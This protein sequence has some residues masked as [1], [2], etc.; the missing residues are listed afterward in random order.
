MPSTLFCDAGGNHGKVPP[1]SFSEDY[2]G[3]A[4]SHFTA[5]NYNPVATGGSTTG[6]DVIEFLMAGAR[7]VQVLTVS[8]REGTGHVQKMISEMT[9]YMT[10]K[11]WNRVE[12]LIGLTLKYLPEDPFASW[13]R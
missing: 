7:G 3:S 2:I 8:M 5:S 6:L 12:D 13:Y 4:A 10:E 11:G 1:Y 9:Q